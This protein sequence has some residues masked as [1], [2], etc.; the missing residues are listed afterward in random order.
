MKVRRLA[1]ILVVPLLAA[2][3]AV[4]SASLATSPPSGC[5]TAA[6][7]DQGTVA[8]FYNSTVAAIRRLPA[9]NDN[10]QLA[11][12]EGQQPAT[13]CYIDGQIPKGPPPPMSGTTPPSY[14][15]AVIVVV[16][17]TSLFMAAGYRTSLPTQRP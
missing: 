2:C 14:D 6:R 1:L 12:Y 7:D 15:R 8:A 9:V 4:G 17:D 10:P 11:G 16:G 13:V 5:A 3:A